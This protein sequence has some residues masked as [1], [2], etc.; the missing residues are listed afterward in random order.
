MVDVESVLQI[1]CAAYRFAMC[2]LAGGLE[3]A[4]SFSEINAPRLG[5]CVLPTVWYNG[6]AS[7]QTEY[8]CSRKCQGRTGLA[9]QMAQHA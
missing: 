5:N 9:G 3:Y 8:L 1:D 6:G 7:R 4:L 2:T